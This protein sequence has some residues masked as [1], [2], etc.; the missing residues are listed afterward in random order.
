MYIMLDLKHSRI[1]R[2]YINNRGCS[3]SCECRY[4]CMMLIIM[5]YVILGCAIVWSFVYV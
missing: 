5:M 4:I 2:L 3:A 1:D